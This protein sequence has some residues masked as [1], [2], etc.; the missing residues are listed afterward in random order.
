[1]AW[2]LRLQEQQV[3]LDDVAELSQ[4]DTSTTVNNQVN[5][6]KTD[7]KPEAETNKADDSEKEE[8][9]SIH[10]SQVD[11]LKMSHNNTSPVKNR[12]SGILVIQ[13]R[14]REEARTGGRRGY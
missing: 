12:K 14:K 5:K 13:R 1:M 2:I 4:L 9:V 11:S 10:L 6:I 3:S 8:T 7:D